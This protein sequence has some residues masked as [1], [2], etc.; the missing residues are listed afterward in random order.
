VSD[1]Q[2]VIERKGHVNK[3]IK[4]PKK[5]AMLTEAGIELNHPYIS[6]SHSVTLEVFTTHYIP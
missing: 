2:R 1:K 3:K 5:R 6:I 4:N